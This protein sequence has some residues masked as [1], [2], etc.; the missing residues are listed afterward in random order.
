[1]E[2][3][4]VAA[5]GDQYTTPTQLNPPLLD[6]TS[7]LVTTSSATNLL[8][9]RVIVLTNCV[10]HSIDS[11]WPLPRQYMPITTVISLYSESLCSELVS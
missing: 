8:L 2:L 1:M 9:K 11:G 10:R 3:A 6:N 4:Y 7:K 5:A